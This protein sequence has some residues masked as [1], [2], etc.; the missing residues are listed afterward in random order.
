MIKSV[1]N[2]SVYNNGLYLNQ[3]LTTESS[4]TIDKLKARTS[5]VVQEVLEKYPLAI[6]SQ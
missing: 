2:Y 5:Q 6:T 4:W 3:A 1:Y